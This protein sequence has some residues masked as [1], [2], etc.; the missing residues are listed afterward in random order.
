MSNKVNFVAIKTISVKLVTILPATTNN[1]NIYWFQ[2]KIPCVVI[3]KGGHFRV[4]SCTLVRVTHRMSSEAR[5]SRDVSSD[6]E[7]E[8]LLRS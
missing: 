5:N 2:N 8:I 3:L 6:R 4:H 7:I 1:V